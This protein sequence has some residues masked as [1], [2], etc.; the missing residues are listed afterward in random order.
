M[1]V[2]YGIVVPGAERVFHLIVPPGKRNPG[3]Q[4]TV[5]TQTKGN[6]NTQNKQWF[7]EGLPSC[8]GVSTRN[9]KEGWTTGKWNKPSSV[10][11]QG[12]CKE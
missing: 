4:Q 7:L 9:Q 1:L 6:K 5:L 12:F 8:F 11:L 10:S 3:S 2:L